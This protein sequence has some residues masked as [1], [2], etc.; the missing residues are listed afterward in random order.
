ML[1]PIFIYI[2]VPIVCLCLH[3]FLCQWMQKQ[4]I[5]PPF[6]ALLL[7][8]IS[9][10]GWL[11]ILLTGLFWQ[12]SGMASLGLF[13]L[14]F[15]APF[16]MLGTAVSIARQQQLSVYHRWVFRASAGYI[17]IVGVVVLITLLGR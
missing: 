17:P 11:I 7:V 3:L 14:L 16:L 12:W 8:M 5:D 9:Y 10:G 13:Y 1:I 15:V 6:W 4:A 2:V